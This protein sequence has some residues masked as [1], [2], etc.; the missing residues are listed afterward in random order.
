MIINER[1]ILASSSPRRKYLLESL[2]RNFNLSFDVIPANISEE[3]PLSSKRPGSLAVRL[4]EIKA[5][6]VARNHRG[7][8]LGADTIVV[9]HSKILGKPLTDSDARR[10]LLLLSN[11]FHYV[12][13]GLYI[14]NTVNGNEFSAYEKTKVFFRKLSRKE[15]DFY[16]RSGSPMDKAG[17]YGI[18]DDFGST[19][20]ASF[21]GDFFN[22]VGLPIVKTY[23]GFQKIIG[24]EM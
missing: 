14:T 16:V 5:K 11:D 8:V 2:L 20:V 7:I 10:M 1:I 6:T 12:Y 21:N 17:G 19:F 22:I 9:L 15:I 13:T 3:L 23:L 18:Q 24:L 4:A